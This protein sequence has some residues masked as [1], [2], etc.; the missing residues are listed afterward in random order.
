MPW[1]GEVPENQNEERVPEMEI[2]TGQVSG[3]RKIG[4]STIRLPGG[5]TMKS[6]YMN[7]EDV[8]RA[9]RQMVYA[10]LADEERMEQDIWADEKGKDLAPCPANLQWV[11]HGANLGYVCTGGVS[12]ILVS[13][14]CSAVRNCQIPNPRGGFF[15]APS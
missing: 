8:A 15:F 12:T 1:S 13:L 2:P 5:K 7:P 10:S 6:A 4:G 3:P 14:L 11:R 9:E